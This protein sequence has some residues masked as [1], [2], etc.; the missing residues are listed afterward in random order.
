[1]PPD[2]LMEVL[3]TMETL[4]ETTDPDLVS[5]IRDETKAKSNAVIQRMNSDFE[6]SDWDEFRKGAVE[7]RYLN[8]IRA[9]CDGWVGGGRRAE[10]LH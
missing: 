1:V 5:T 2:L 7:L 10:M 4:Q 3:E 9:A 6:K 8:N